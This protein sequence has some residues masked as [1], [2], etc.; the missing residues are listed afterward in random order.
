MLEN[1]F[2]IKHSSERWENNRFQIFKIN[3][4]GYH[5]YLL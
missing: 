1:D 5:S 4:N 3:L 2:E